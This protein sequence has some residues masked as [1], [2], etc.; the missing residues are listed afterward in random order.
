MI[1]WALIFSMLINSAVLFVTMRNQA[2]ERKDMLDRLMSS[3]L[4]E[5][6]ELTEPVP[7]S[8]APVSLT[9]EEEWIK[10]IEMMN[11]ARN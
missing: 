7:A 8:G 9:E 3:D 1:E 6:K 4:V 11:S 5:Y 10:E 2:A